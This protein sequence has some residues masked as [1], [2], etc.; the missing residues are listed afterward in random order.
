MTSLRLRSSG[1]ILTVTPKE[2][3]RRGRSARRPRAG[4]MKHHAGTAPSSITPEYPSLPTMHQ[5]SSNELTMVTRSPIERTS[6]SGK[7]GLKTWRTLRA[8]WAPD[9]TVPVEA[10]VATDAIEK[11]WEERLGTER[12]ELRA[13]ERKDEVEDRLEDDSPPI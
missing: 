10:V 11:R 6:S 12:K 5:P 9:V 1:S 7:T 3:V 4:L 8:P 13:T 2:E